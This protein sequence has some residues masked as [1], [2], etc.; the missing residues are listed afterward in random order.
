MVDRLNTPLAAI[1]HQCFAET[2]PSRFHILE[3]SCGRHPAVAGLPSDAGHGILPRQVERRIKVIV[4]VLETHECNLQR[5]APIYHQYSLGS[6]QWYR[7]RW[8]AASIGHWWSELLS[9]TG[10]P[11]PS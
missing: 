9:A 6:W 7:E 1:R 11:N 2:V 4:Q 8:L 10:I 5:N 3:T